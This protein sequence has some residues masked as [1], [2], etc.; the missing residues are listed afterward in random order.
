MRLASLMQFTLPGVPCIYYGDEA[1]M[2]GYRDPFN[3]ACYPW[4]NEEKDLVEWYRLLG[5]LRRSCPALK[6]GDFLP[7]LADGSCMGYIRRDDT[8]SMLC[9][10]NAGGES[11]RVAVPKEWLNA[12]AAV[13][14][15]PD[16]NNTLFLGP[17]DCAVLLLKQNNSGAAPYP[18]NFRN[19]K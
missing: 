8:V 17:E 18:N 6:E 13:G 9:L 3:R 11:R 4:G 12:R 14:V 5:R 16:E 2:E 1:G 10:I 7:F 19:E 15:V